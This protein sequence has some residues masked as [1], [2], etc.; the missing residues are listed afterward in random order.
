[1]L[2]TEATSVGWSAIQYEV[3]RAVDSLRWSTS[4]SVFHRVESVNCR[5]TLAGVVG[6]HVVPSRRPI[7]PSHDSASKTTCFGR[8]FQSADEC[9][10]LIRRGRFVLAAR[11]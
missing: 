3:V 1:M 10:T 5:R 7:D 9:R 11:D 8:N 6:Q 4:I 2:A